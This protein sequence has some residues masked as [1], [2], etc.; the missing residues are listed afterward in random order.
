MT[1]PPP[2]ARSREHSAARRMV[3]RRLHPDLGGDPSEFIEA[4]RRVDEHYA[5]GDDTGEI[6]VRRSRRRRLR[7]L[8]RR[9][10]ARLRA[11]LPATWPGA[12]RYG[13]L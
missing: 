13:T 3:A 7:R 10:L 6:E 2:G 5:E 9:G 8:T 12:R 1:S 11:R 4:L